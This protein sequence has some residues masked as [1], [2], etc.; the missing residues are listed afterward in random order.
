LHSSA[1]SISHLLAS[2]LRDAVRQNVGPGLLLQ[3][4]ALAMLLS[5]RFWPGARAALEA[6]MACKLA[7][8][9]GYSFC[10]G[11]LFAGL[12]PRVVMRLTGVHRGPLA[13]E[14]AFAVPFWG[15]KGVEVDAFYRLQ[16]WLFGNV[17][18][19]PT[20]LEKALVDQLVYS[21]LWAVP[22]IALAYLWKDAGYR[23]AGVRAQLDREFFVLR[24]P[25]LLLGNAMVWTPTV[26]V[27]YFLPAAL[28]LPVSNLVAT[29][30][31]LLMVVLL[32]RTTRAAQ[33]IM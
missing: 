21:P 29:F 2:R 1:S 7:W 28:Q 15:Y 13:P 23:L 8:G 31:V 19:W 4:A 3:G 27:I 22:S 10:T 33:E 20:V 32:R 14:L 11:A 17:A 9:F 18:D 30:W 24:L 5:W 16:G 25:S 26:V 6:L 12:L